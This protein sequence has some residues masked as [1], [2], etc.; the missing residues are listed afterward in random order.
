MSVDCL[1]M[2]SSLFV[3]VVYTLCCSRDL[4]VFRNL[5][6]NDQLDQSIKGHFPSEDMNQ[7]LLFRSNQSYYV[8]IVIHCINYCFFTYCLH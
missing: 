7:S 1:M 2:T 6:C 5:Y 3:I 8:L 4:S